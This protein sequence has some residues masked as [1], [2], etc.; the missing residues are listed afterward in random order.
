MSKLTSKEK[1]EQWITLLKILI[2]ITL[3]VAFVVSA[4]ILRIVYAKM[5][6]MHYLLHKDVLI[7]NA[8]QKKNVKRDNI[9]RD[10]KVY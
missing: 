9:T 7:G 10:W 4:V 6:R 3:G 1:L 2:P 8:W 5:R